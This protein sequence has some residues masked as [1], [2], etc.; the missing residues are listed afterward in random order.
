VPHPFS[1]ALEEVVRPNRD[2]II[3]AVRD[4]MVNLESNGREAFALEGE[5]AGRTLS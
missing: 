2:K 1:P 5:G 4:M 3:Q